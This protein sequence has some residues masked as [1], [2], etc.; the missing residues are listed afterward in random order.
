MAKPKR[1]RRSL[2]LTHVMPDARGVGLT[3]R[4]WSWA[5]ELSAQCDLEILLVSPH[6]Q[7]AAPTDLPGVLHVLRRAGP[8]LS[9][10]WLADW[11]EPDATVAAA[12]SSL[13]GPPPDRI[14]VFRFFMHDVAALLPL[15]WR[16]R[17]EIDC[18]DWEAGTRLSLAAIALRRGDY[19]MAS[20]RFVEAARYAR[21]ERKLLPLYPMVHVAAREDADLMRRLYRIPDIR[22][23]PNRIAPEPGL[24]SAPRNPGANMLLFVGA[25]F[26]P[27]NEDAMMWFGEAV[28]PHLRRLAPQMRVVAAGR[29]EDRLQ[30]RLA[31]DGIE[32]VHAPEDLRPLYEQA[33]AV[34]VPVRG[35]GGTKLKV[36][37][38]WLHQRPLVATSHAMRGLVAREE[39]HFLRADRPLDF[40]RACA[41][42]LSD[43][44]LAARLAREG[45]ALL[46]ERYLLD[47]YHPIESTR[48]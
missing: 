41:K 22:T 13:A 37:E 30:R 12:L 24:T 23:S 33:A 18:D 43:D 14:V 39:Q 11:F 17:A 7:P 32:Y 29:A 16:E 15:E 25:L 4:A 40:A 8:P 21:L 19:A 6:P 2:L 42:L 48:G 3:R 10:R 34:I 31:R 36:L 26:Y 20:R 45:R 1:G 27:P 44:E 47:G 46:R 28:L 38:A 9:P 5:A 35:G